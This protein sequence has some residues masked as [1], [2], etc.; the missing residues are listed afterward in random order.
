MV[1][2]CLVIT[3]ILNEDEFNNLP[4]QLSMTTT[5]LPFHNFLDLNT[6]EMPQN[7]MAMKSLTSHF[8]V[9]SLLPQNMNSRLGI[10]DLTLV[11]MVVA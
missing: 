9:L 2:S 4:Q 6:D 8:I 10:Y 3:T 7:K 11:S 1:V 5:L